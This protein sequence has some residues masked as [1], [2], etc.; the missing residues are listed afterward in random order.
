MVIL[1]CVLQRLQRRTRLEMAARIEPFLH[2]AESMTPQEAH[3]QLYTHLD[4]IYGELR[5]ACDHELADLAKELRWIVRNSAAR[6]M[7][8]AG[9][10]PALAKRL[11]RFYGGLKGDDNLWLAWERDVDKAEVRANKKVV[12]KAKASKHK[13]HDSGHR[14]RSKPLKRSRS[15][16]GGKDRRALSDDGSDSEGESEVAALKRALF[17][18][19]KEDRFTRGCYACGSDRHNFGPKCPKLDDVRRKVRRAESSK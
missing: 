18:L 5:I 19:P 16:H 8:K 13:S 3:G 4:E 12:L 2:E 6:G 10:G 1:V 15:K 9:F 17:K 11:K 14:D 7:T